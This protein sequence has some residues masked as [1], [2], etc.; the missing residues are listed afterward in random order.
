MISLKSAPRWLSIAYA[1]H[2]A[3]FCLPTLMLFYSFKGLGMGDF[4]LI[5][6]ISQLS[7]FILEIPT[8]YIGDLFSRKS[9]L[10]IGTLAWIV[11]H[12]I[13]IFGSGFCIILTGELLF[14]MAIA[15]ISGTLEA[16]L[17]DLLKKRHKEGVFH[18]K[19][20]K[21]KMLDSLSL[22]IATLSGAFIYQFLG[23]NVPLWL[24][25]FCLISSLII[26]FLLPDVPESKRIV[27]KDKSKW[28]DIIDISKYAIKHPEIKWLMLF[29]ALYG[30]LTF[31]FMWGLQSVMIATQ[32]PIFVFSFVMGLTAFTRTFLSGITGRILEK[33]QL[34][35]IIKLQ[36]F[37]IVIA[38]IASCLAVYMPI[39]GVYICLGIMIIG[40]ASVVL[41]N[42][43]SSVLINHRIKSDERATILSVDS[44]IS[45]AFSGIGLIC[46]KPLFDG[47]GVG[48]TFMVSA[49]LL[50]P[51]LICARHLYKMKLKTMRQI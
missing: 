19:Y 3:L 9:T 7:I 27:A 13:W 36:S 28:Q 11:G 25:V 35:G 32:L 16:Y 50:I 12:L 4:F 1:L 18:K 24:S 42:I 38:A 21:M 6:G 41:S 48:P 46:L 23:P 45:K 8:G 34:S 43:A 22:T 51:I 2:G 20:A 37:I 49:L 33:I 26:L 10:I 5:Q 17:Y 47:I 31:V 44:M 39:L 30:T 15:F 40:A 29:P 14:G